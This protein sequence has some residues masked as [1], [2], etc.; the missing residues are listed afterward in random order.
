MLVVIDEF[1]ENLLII[2]DKLEWVL[3][4]DINEFV[5]EDLGKIE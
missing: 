3:I 5:V 2:N 4:F 1:S